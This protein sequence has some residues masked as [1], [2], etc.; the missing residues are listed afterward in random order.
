MPGQI[1]GSAYLDG[2]LNDPDTVYDSMPPIAAVLAAQ[3]VRPDSGLSMLRAIQHGHYRS[4]VRVVEVAVLTD[5]AARIGLPREDFLREFASSTAHQAGGHIADTRALMQRVGAQGFP[6][7]L[8]H[9]RR[10]LAIAAACPALRRAGGIR[11]AGGT[12]LRPGLT[13]GRAGYG[14]SGLFQE[15]ALA[16]GQHQGIAIAMLAHRAA[17]ECFRG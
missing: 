8:L 12:P 9:H 15:A 6:T 4:G 3:A 11:E 16:E 10:P 13:D 14:K 7:F 1:F 5:L 17:S 2:L